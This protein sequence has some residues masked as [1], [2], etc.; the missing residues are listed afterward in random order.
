[1][2]LLE[3]SR[4]A[5]LAFALAATACDRPEPPPVAVRAPVLEAE[6][7]A[8]IRALFDH[9]LRA[10]ERESLRAQGL[11]PRFLIVNTTAAICRRDPGVLGPPP[12]RCLSPYHANV[13]SEVVPPE[14]FPT[15]KL[16]F[17]SWNASGMSIS[18]ELGDDVTL[19]SPTLLDMMPV[20]DLL[21]R[22]P[23][24]STLMWLSTPGYPAPGTAVVVFGYW[25]HGGARLE[26]QQDG[27][28]RVVA[29]AWKPQD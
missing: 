2:R 9:F 6:D 14:M 11:S 19:V 22:H 12:G 29:T 17:P 21:R 7:V 23:R 10:P 15:V 1:V 16:F 24:G 13:L 3:A 26:R 5:L 28:W 8:V 20:S 18:G 27:S 4:A 25:A